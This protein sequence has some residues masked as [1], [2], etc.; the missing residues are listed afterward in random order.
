MID[1]LTYR[2][3]P[4]DLS[5]YSGARLAPQNEASD[6]VGGLASTVFGPIGPGLG[7]I[8]KLVRS[9]NPAASALTNPAPQVGLPAS[10]P[11]GVK[12][13]SLVGQRAIDINDIYNDQS[14]EDTGDRF[15]GGFLPSL[16]FEGI[17]SLVDKKL[18]TVAKGLMNDPEANRKKEGYIDI[19]GLGQ[20]ARA[21]ST[22]PNISFVGLGRPSG[23]KNPNNKA[24]S[25]T[26]SNAISDADRLRAADVA[27]YA[28][29][30]PTGSENNQNRGSGGL[31]GLGGL[32]RGGADPFGRDPFGRGGADR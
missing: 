3:G 26:N 16:D 18:G 11:Y 31:G 13:A 22:H 12:A 17:L 2:G 29:F 5:G 20:A 9:V 27:A 30:G 10:N 4:N 21:L 19:A 24:S 14:E 28:N 8:N 7:F 15:F 23:P 1:F 25:N 6:V 32:S